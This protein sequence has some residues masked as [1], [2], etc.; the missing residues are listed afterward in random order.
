MVLTVGRRHAVAILVVVISSACGGPNP[1]PSP[2]SIQETPAPSR[3]AAPS[4]SESVPAPTE[5]HTA[6]P[7]TSSP[8]PALSVSP[9]ASQTDSPA[10][11][12]PLSDISGS[13]LTYQLPDDYLTTNDVYDLDNDGTNVVYVD[14]RGVGGIGQTVWL[15][16]LATGQRKALNQAEPHVGTL[17]PRVSGNDVVWSAGNEVG[18]KRLTW[19]LM[20]FDLSTGATD[21]IDHGINTR[22]EDGS[23]SGPAT[24]LD[25]GTVAYTVESAT[26]AY[27]YGWKIVL[28][29]LSD[30]V[31]EREI[32]TRYAVWEM[33][34]Q[35]GNVLYNEVPPQESGATVGGL[36]LSTAQHPDP[37]QIGDNGGGLAIDGERIVWD[38]S[39]RISPNSDVTE[40][41]V[42]TAT[43]SDLTPVP[44]ARG[45]DNEDGARYS[46]GGDGL[47]AWTESSPPYDKLYMWDSATGRTYEV[48]GQFD[49]LS[50]LHGTF[51]PSIAG[52]WLTWE[53]ALGTDTQLNAQFAAIRTDD[54]RAAE[55]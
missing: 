54:L 34:I 29:R 31:V 6:I 21:T 48:V 37:V 39:A 38:G 33:A 17:G 20:H 53:A 51:L 22:L 27:P 30:G 36:M 43:F 5:S 26:A 3:S 1:S 18:S 46:T 24:A 41:G 12:L 52:G 9:T 2:S 19:R 25:A 11:V 32:Q 15:I 44:L 50:H 7:S 13:L 45:T 4:V 10:T 8:S 47:V 28:R 49:T 35:D 42:F 55:P 14:L 23:P 16:D 40:N